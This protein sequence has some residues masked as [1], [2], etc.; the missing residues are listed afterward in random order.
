MTKNPNQ[1]DE[2]LR[3]LEILQKKQDQFAK[4]IN[5]L[6][7]EIGRIKIAEVEHSFSEQSIAIEDMPKTDPANENQTFINRDYSLSDDAE[8]DR[9][10]RKYT[11]KQDDSKENSNLEKFIG[12]NLIN[13][14]GIAITIIGVS[15]G[16]KYSI[17][18]ELISPL[19]RVLL[20]YLAGLTLLFFGIRLKS[21]YENYSAVLVSGSMAILYFMTYAAYTFYGLVSQIPAFALMVMITACT[22]VAALKY[23]RIVIALIG[24]VG[25]YAIPFLLSN[26]SS[27]AAILFSYVAIINIGI[28]VIA[29]KKYWESLYYASF[30]LTWL[31]YFAWFNSTYKPESDFG[32][33]FAFLGIFFGIFYLTFLAYKV[34]KNAKFYS[35]DIPLLLGNTA[36]FFGLGYILVSGQKGLEGR[37]GLF[38]LLNAMIHCSVALAL[39]LKKHADKNLFYFITGLALVFVTIAI[40]VQLE[41]NWVT[42]LWAGEFA[43]LFWIGRTQKVPVYEIL[44]YPIMMLTF[45]SLIHCW[46]VGYFHPISED[47]ATMVPL[48]NEYFVTTLMVA[49]SFGIVHL[50]NSKEQYTSSISNQE[51]FLSLVSAVIPSILLFTIYFSFRNEIAFYWNQMHFNAVVKAHGSWNNYYTDFFCTDLLYLKNIWIINYSLLFFSILSFLNIQHIKNRSLGLVNLFINLIVTVVFITIQLYFLE[52][53]GD[54]LAKGTTLH[55][56][57]SFINIWI[58]YIS[59][60]FLALMLFASHRYVRQDFLKTDYSIVF[61]LVLFTSIICVASS[62]LINWMN[63]AGSADSFKLGLSIL[64]GVYSLLIVAVGI[65]KKKKYLRIGAIALFSCTLIKLFFYDLSSLDTISKTIVF[66]SLGVLL[67][68]ISFIYNKYKNIIT[69]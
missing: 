30:V 31:I 67:L 57:H 47:S 62:E 32:L 23:D 25:A 69:D 13:K 37:L 56:Q 46:S 12:E 27:N 40:P 11:G 42:L 19:A 58:R 26:D 28:L 10:M 5:Q 16:V 18:H 17:D 38:T 7:I 41:G 68:I 20:G 44:S 50:I 22:V 53:L 8:T 48:F 1:A 60:G 54:N 45:L 49:L 36:I 14:I 34:A 6:H 66:V 35:Q 4:E 3:K 2:L 55:D 61:D 29:V 9:I 59:F 65:W 43:L 33:A 51:D 39:H 52:K 21:K 64:W 24:L 15:I 63:V